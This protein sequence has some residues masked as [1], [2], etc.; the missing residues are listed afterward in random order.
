MKIIILLSYIFLYSCTMKTSEDTIEKCKK[1]IV[2]TE[3]NFARMVKNDGVSAAFLAYADK[4]AVL[5]RNNIL[6][7]GKKNIRLYFENQSEENTTINLSW[8]PDFIEVSKSGDLGYTYGKYKHSFINS[9]GDT[10]NTKGFFHTIWKKQADET[11]K[12]VWD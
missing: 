3:Q 8:K 2:K 12:F 4:N 11:W 1:E 6:I 5:M 9:K 7:N 10:I